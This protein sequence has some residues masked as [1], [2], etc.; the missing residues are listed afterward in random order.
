M[1]FSS[2]QSAQTR[3]GGHCCSD[4][5][6]AAEGVAER[7][8]IHGKWNTSVQCTMEADV[9]MLH[10]KSLETPVDCYAIVDCKL[11][12]FGSHMPD[13]CTSFVLVLYGRF[14]FF[15]LIGLLRKSAIYSDCLI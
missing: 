4:A 13:R 14:S 6:L 1:L 10:V 3:Q 11:G 9:V 2:V 7:N 15:F 12:L 5:K 8:C